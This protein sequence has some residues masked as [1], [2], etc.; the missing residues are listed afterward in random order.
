MDRKAKRM[1]T[2]KEVAEITGASVNSIR[3]WLND[4]VKKRERFPNAERMSSPRGDY[5]LIPESD[6]KGYQNPGRGRP[7]KKPADKGKKKG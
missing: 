2:V 7:R 3:V 1:L 4:E 5:W 6:L